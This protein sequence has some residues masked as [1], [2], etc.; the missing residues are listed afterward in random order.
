MSKKIVEKHEAGIRPF[1]SL[2]EGD[3]LH[4]F[5]DI[6]DAAK[7][8]GES[9]VDPNGDIHPLFS[10]SA[11]GL[12]ECPE[13]FKYQLTLIRLESVESVPVAEVK[14]E[15][16]KVVEPVVEAAPTVDIVK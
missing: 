2:N 10:V 7:H 6:A 4:Y 16:T 3:T 15:P 1:A 14:P 12:V 11:D 8:L 13:G 5:D 9:C